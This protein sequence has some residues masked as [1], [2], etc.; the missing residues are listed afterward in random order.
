M[1]AH[2][3]LFSFTFNAFLLILPFNSNQRYRRSRDLLLVDN[4]H[5]IGYICIMKLFDWNLGK[6]EELKARRKISFE[7]IV[8]SI[9]RDGLLDI[10]EHPDQQRYPD[11]RIFIVNVDDY[12]YIVPF[13]E[14]EKA[15]FL[16][17]IIPSRKMTRKYLGGKRR[18]N[19]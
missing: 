3:S 6:N 4:K 8:F 10:L 12:A 1:L 16:K 9:S 11:Q 14:D 5:T 18:E 13:I 17:T 15:I 7:D 19:E 2:P